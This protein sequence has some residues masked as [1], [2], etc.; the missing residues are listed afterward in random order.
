M[1]NQPLYVQDCS[2]A[3]RHRRGHQPGWSLIASLLGVLLF[4]SRVF[5]A[6][7]AEKDGL[8]A[9]LFFDPQQLIVLGHPF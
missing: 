1:L 2:C 5:E 8:F 6:S 7:L 4:C 3:R 9:K